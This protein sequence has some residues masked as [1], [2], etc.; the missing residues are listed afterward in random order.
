MTS[1]TEKHDLNLNKAGILY[2]QQLPFK[3]EIRHG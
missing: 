1:V 2:Q 3:K